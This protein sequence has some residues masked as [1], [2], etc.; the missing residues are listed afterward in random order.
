MNYGNY[1]AMRTRVPPLQRPYPPVPALGAARAFSL[2]ELLFTL[3]LIAIVSGLTIAWYARAHQD[4]V[5]RVI[6]QRNAQEIVTLGVGATLGGADFVVPG[7]KLATVQNLLVGVV[8]QQGTWKG[9]IFR[10]TG[11][12][13]DSVPGATEFVKLDGDLLIYDP[14]GDQE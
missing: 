8:G 6:D 14:D 13:P 5:M 11:M 10:L 2:L 1:A 12:H 4:A 9:K 3:A 7:D